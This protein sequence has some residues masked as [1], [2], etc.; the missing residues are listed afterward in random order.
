MWGE[1]E[2]SAVW[3]GIICFQSPVVNVSPATVS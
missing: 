2:E 3:L 1:K